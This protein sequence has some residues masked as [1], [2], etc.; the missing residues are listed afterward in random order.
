MAASRT[1]RK[2]NNRGGA[3][4]S[5]LREE[6]HRP[7]VRLGPHGHSRERLRN[8]KTKAP[9]EVRVVS[10]LVYMA[11]WLRDRTAQE[12]GAEVASV[13]PAFRDSRLS[14]RPRHA[15]RVRQ[16]QRGIEATA[17]KQT[18]LAGGGDEYELV[19][20]GGRV[21]LEKRRDRRNGGDRNPR[22]RPRRANRAKGRQGH[23]SVA[24]PVRR[25]DDEPGRRDGRGFRTHGWTQI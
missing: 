14:R 1:R 24:E 13:A 6:R 11:G 4:H 5:M 21:L 23:H 8:V 2:S 12:P 18:D 9:Y 22:V 20:T 3:V 17:R 19:L 10:G 25:T 15:E 7:R 16:Q